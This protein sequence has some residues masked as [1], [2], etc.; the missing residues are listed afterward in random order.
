[1]ERCI[2]F[3]LILIPKWRI[4]SAYVLLLIYVAAGQ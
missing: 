1:M 4:R 3:D 2:G